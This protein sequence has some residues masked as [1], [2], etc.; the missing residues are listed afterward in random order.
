VNVNK[1]ADNI[2]KKFMT[3]I[4][5]VA[6]EEYGVTRENKYETEDT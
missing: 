6:I 5:E 1:D 2:W 4:R 3:H